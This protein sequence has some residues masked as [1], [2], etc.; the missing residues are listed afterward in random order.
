MNETA[1]G[2][3]VESD[4][5]VGMSPEQFKINHLLQRVAAITAEYEDKM[6]NG[7]MQLQMLVQERDA[8]KAKVDDLTSQL[9]SDRPDVE[10]TPRP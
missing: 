7:T 1:N 2:P 6:A 4:P 3:G 5:Q 8:L 10:E 9:D